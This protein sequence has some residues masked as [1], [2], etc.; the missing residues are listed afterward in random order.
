[1]SR[2]VSSRVCDA[3]MMRLIVPMFF[4]WGVQKDRPVQVLSPAWNRRP[5]KVE[6][7]LLHTL[8]RKMQ[9]RWAKNRIT[10]AK[11]NSFAICRPN[12]PGGHEAAEPFSSQGHGPSGLK[13]NLCLILQDGTGQ[14]NATSISCTTSKGQ[15]PGNSSH[16]KDQVDLVIG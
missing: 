2:R 11:K 14:R 7:K 8:R 5:E 16:K 12:D 9:E 15:N 1:M 13:G 10:C 3:C 6:A 4:L